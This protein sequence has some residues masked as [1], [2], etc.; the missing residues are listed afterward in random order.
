V[1]RITPPRSRHDA[2]VLIAHRLAT[3]SRADDI[4]ILEDGRVIEAGERAALAADPESVFAHL[5]V[6]G[7]EEALA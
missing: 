5:L 4:V 2:R 3:V 7:M 1:A 6:A